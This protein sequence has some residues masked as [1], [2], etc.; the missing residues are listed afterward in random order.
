[1][2]FEAK[3]LIK[4]P[5]KSLVGGGIVQAKELLRIDLGESIAI[6]NNDGLSSGL[7]D[8][9][10]HRIRQTVFVGKDDPP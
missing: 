10:R 3:R 8:Q 6:A 4:L 2:G 9:I 5:P 7:P 1:M